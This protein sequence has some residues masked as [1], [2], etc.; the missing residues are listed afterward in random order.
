MTER[1]INIW[2]ALAL[3]WM[4]PGLGHLYA[5]RGKYAA[6]YFVCIGGLYVAGWVLSRGTAV[7]WDAHGTYFLLQMLASPITISLEF[8]RDRG[9]VG[10]G[11][12]L[13]IIDHQSGTVYAATA[14]LLNLITLCELH[15]RHIAPD[16]P[17]PGDTLRAELV[18]KP[19][20]DTPAEAKA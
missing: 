20:M 13:P 8:L 10:L 1:K 9:D 6:F 15:R 17:G 7:S 16:A 2:F 4:V 11:D 19:K 14:G 3:G 18:I 12:T 5:R